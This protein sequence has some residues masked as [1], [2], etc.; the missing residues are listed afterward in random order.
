MF[1]FGK[2]LDSMDTIDSLRGKFSVNRGSLHIMFWV[3][4]FVYSILENWNVS[5]YKWA[6]LEMYLTKLPLQIAVAYF[7]TYVLLPEFLFKKK[8]FTFFSL[9][10]LSVY[11][12]CAL[13]ST[14]KVFYFEQTYPTY[15]KT[16][17]IPS[18]L[19]YFDLIKFLMYAT[20]FYTPAAIMAIIKLVRTQHEEQQKRQSIEKEM[21]LAELNFLKIQLNPHFLFNTLNNL[22]ML[23]LK[24]S[25]EAPEVVAKL[26]ETLDYM[27]YRCHEQ[28]VPLEGEIKLI[29][30]YLSLEKLRLGNDVIVRFNNDEATTSRTIAPLIMLSLVEN[31][32]KHGVN[33]GIAKSEVDIDLHLNNADLTFTVR[34]T[35]KTVNAFRTNGI[36]LKN[37][38]RQLEL[39]YPKKHKLSINETDKYYSAKLQ[40][41]LSD[42]E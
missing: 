2:V 10:L 42:P 13:Y 37:I 30:N 36:G 20:S 1:K 24:S 40:L 21:L 6:V 17:T 14:Y 23:T 38:R 16:V 3:A 19:I 5:D 31:A 11:I 32:F 25:P 8:Y 39:I 15:F 33:N 4:V 7:V 26:S 35:K 12:T 29:E 9:L 22:Y 41:T 18:Y 34:N 28:V 27:L